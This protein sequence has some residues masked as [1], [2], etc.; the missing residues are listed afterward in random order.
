M[1]EIRMLLHMRSHQQGHT[2]SISDWTVSHRRSHDNS[3]KL[4]YGTACP[5]LETAPQILFLNVSGEGIKSLSLSVVP[6]E[7]CVSL[8]PTRTLRLHHA[9]FHFYPGGTDGRERKGLSASENYDLA[10]SLWN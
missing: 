3:S 4:E 7:L 8:H 9:G 6:S 10:R 5:V 2:V 1:L